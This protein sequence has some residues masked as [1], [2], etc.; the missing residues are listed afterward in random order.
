MSDKRTPNE[1]KYKQWTT[2]TNGGRRYWRDVRGRLGWTARYIKEV[3]ADETTT[4]FRQ[5]IY[6]VDG[7]LVE[8]HNKFPRDEGHQR[9]NQ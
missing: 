6:D 7:V 5:E 9:R 2:L 8:V 1:R 4:L 3:D